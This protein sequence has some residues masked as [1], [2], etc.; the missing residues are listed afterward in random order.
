MM[1]P[2]NDIRLRDQIARFPT[3][4]GVYLFRGE[5]G[6]VLY[7]GKA[8]NLRARAR[9]YL[10]EGADGRYH[11]QFLMA[12]AHSVEYMVT[13][14]EQEA[15]ILENNLI[16]KYRP[17]YNIFL[18]DDKT[19]V[20]LRL[21][22]AH[23]FPRLTVVRRPRRDGATYFGPFASVGSVR[24]TV[25]T[26]GRIFPLRTCSD[27]EFAA[28][29]R[30]CLYYYIKRC[31]AP[32]VGKVDAQEYGE[33][34]RRVSMFLR[35]RGH[36]LIRSLR[37]KMELLAAERRYEEAASTRDQVFAIQSVLER[38][39]IT[40]PQASERDVFAVCR[41]DERLVVHTLHVR[42]GAVSDG[43]AY[44]FEH[45]VLPVADHLA[46][47]ISQYYQ[48]GEAIPEEVIVGV[49]LAEEASLATF[50]S[51][52]RGKRV[53]IVRPQRG[54]RAD[55]L[56]LARKNAEMVLSERG[57]AG[58]NR[59]LLE[60]IRELLSL[61]RYPRRIECY[62]ISNLHG[63]DAVGS[64][65]TFI[66]GEPSKAHY[67]HY[68]I[69]TVKRSNDYAMMREI[70][71][72]RVSRGLRE[73]D[74]PDLLV[75][76]GGR[77][78]LGVA[79]DVLDRLGASDVDAVGIAKVRANDGKRKVRG[80]ERLY[81]RG[82]AHPLLLEG[83]QPALYL[84]ERVRDEAHRFAITH[85]RRR[86]RRRTNTSR[87]DGIRGIGPVLRQRLLANFGSVARIRTASEE[88][89]ASVP[90]VSR[91]LARAVKDALT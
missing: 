53:R 61:T 78:Q 39:R 51:Q 56:V 19:Y 44:T 4:P 35:G 87:L 36:E 30:P 60:D 3:G 47:F 69:R 5:S 64:G 24:S 10:R 21:N 34:V 37:E 16:K 72:R 23:P 1:T 77:G 63:T 42:D 50:L 48:S 59:E 79:L 33:T 88:A 66:D 45:A 15:L 29:M 52:R 57:G 68:K 31:P 76:D 11:I 81:L 82:V 71:E 38:Q 6:G 20:N 8:V 12:R 27:H 22:T 28:R 70:M 41:A 49:E 90:G 67:R 9:S 84:L 17:R 85:H 32:C 26:I 46:S 80:K 7:V 55:V 65:V 13:E 86:R 74:L 18:K 40:S 89:I 43:R 73:G 58:R 62:D 54:E 75:I 2:S 14:T 25:R 83:N 91:R